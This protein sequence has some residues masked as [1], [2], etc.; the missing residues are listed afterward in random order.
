MIIKKCDRCKCI[1][2]SIDEFVVVKS[3][4]YSFDLCP[5]CAT[6]FG[7]LKKCLV[8]SFMS[9]PNRSISIHIGELETA[10]EPIQRK[11]DGCRKGSCED[12]EDKYT[13]EFSS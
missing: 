10:N 11:L 4:G 1:Q 9:Y 5:S 6:Y 7:E 12:C 3:C 8:T 2:D 13:C